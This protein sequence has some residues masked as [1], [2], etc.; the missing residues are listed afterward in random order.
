MILLDTQVLLWFVS[1]DKRLRA[2]TWK[3]VA[4]A[5]EA[6]EAAI[7]PISFWEAAMLVSKG[8]IHLGL[9]ADVWAYEICSSDAGPKVVPLT[10]VVAASAGQLAG[11]IHGDP[12][13][14]IIIATARAHGFAL[15][16]TDEKILAYAEAG[17]VQAIDARR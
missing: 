3:L 17:H 7:S 14:R 1:G 16:T 9:P 5:A 10:P 11:G 15:L 2:A 6:G 13:D 4:D 8:R 12:A